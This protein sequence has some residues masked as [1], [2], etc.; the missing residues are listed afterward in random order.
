MIRLPL[1]CVSMTMHDLI[2]AGGHFGVEQDRGLD[3][4]L[5][6][7]LGRKGNLEQDLLHD[8]GAESLRRDFDG[9]PLEE[10][11]LEAPA[12]RGERAGVAH[13]ALESEQ[14]MP[15]GAARRIAGGPTLAR[16]G[17]RR[18]AIGSECPAVEEGVRERIH[19]IGTRAAEHARADGRRSDAHEQDVVEADAVEGILES[20]H[21]LDFVGLY[22]RDQDV[23]HSDR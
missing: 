2:E 19:D 7:E 23:V 22:H 13:L 16:A 20:E 5:R 18:V 4:R 9:V 3:G 6:V 12:R 21:A 17:V 8:V 15:H 11:V 1:S 10:H 14:G